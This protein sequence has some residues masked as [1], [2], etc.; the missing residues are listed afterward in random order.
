MYSEMSP[1]KPPNDDMTDINLGVG[2]TYMLDTAAVASCFCAVCCG[3]FSSVCVFDRVSCNSFTRLLKCLSLVA[4]P[5]ARWSIARRV[6][7]CCSSTP[8]LSQQSFSLRQVAIVLNSRHYSGSI[9]CNN[10]E[11]A[12]ARYDTNFTVK[13]DAIFKND[14][15]VTERY[16]L[17][18]FKDLD[19]KTR[20]TST[21]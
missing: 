14:P 8:S 12:F 5:L 4:L 3:L 15:T 10:I 18:R 2:K 21:C 17:L 1:T 20:R 9:F 6:R 11:N 16:T 7:A 19:E 13:K